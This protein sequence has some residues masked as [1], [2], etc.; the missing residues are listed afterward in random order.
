MHQG[1][2]ERWTAWTQ[3]LTDIPAGDDSSTGF[4]AARDWVRARGGGPAQAL[5]HFLGPATRPAPQ[6]ALTA[7]GDLWAAD[8]THHHLSSLHRSGGS[9][10]ALVAHTAGGVLP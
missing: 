9:I 10:T 5:V 3:S 8:G 1:A 7:D 6:F 4:P 2:R